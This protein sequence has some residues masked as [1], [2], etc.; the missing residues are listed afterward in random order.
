MCCS[1]ICVALE[2]FEKAPQ[3]AAVST[4]YV[5]DCQ[6]QVYKPAR[7]EYSTGTGDNVMPRSNRLGGSRETRPP[8]SKSRKQDKYAALVMVGKIFLMNTCSTST[9]VGYSN[10]SR[11]STRIATDFCSEVGRLAGCS[12]TERVKTVRQVCW[13][14]LVART[15]HQ[16]I[17]S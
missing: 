10:L 16:M 3:R 1:L 17:N 14:G 4:F 12:L 15:V 2:E 9:K 13:L 8:T 5:T 11:L 6:F 7:P